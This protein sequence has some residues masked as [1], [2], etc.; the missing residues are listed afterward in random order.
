MI[1]WAGGKSKLVEKLLKYIPDSFGTYYEP[2]FGGGALF[3]NLK[4]KGKIEN[5][6][7]SDINREVVNLLHVVQIRSMDLSEELLN[8]RNHVGKLQFYQ[9]REEFNSQLGKSKD[10]AKR[11]AMFI[12]LNRN[13]FNGLWRTN[14]NGEYN[15]PYGFYRSYY[16]PSRE[17]IDVYNEL[18]QDTAIMEGDFSKSLQLC[19]KGDLVYLDPP[20]HTYSGFTQYTGLRFTLIEQ[21]KLAEFFKE[22]SKTGIALIESNSN[23]PD[24]LELYRGF[25]I[26]SVKGYSPICSKNIGRGITNEVII[27]N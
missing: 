20:Y 14:R 22:L 24:L 12:Y 8:Y 21:T 15:V 26:N 4:L 13:G 7:V 5:A 16:L 3:W 2:F 18:L 17:V 23:H 6:V 27:T 25:K 11:A 1:K 10:M 19:K 9:V